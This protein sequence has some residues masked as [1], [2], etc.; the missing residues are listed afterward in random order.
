MKKY[1]RLISLLLA[2]VLVCLSAVT[3]F[4]ED[5]DDELEQKLWEL[6]N[7]NLEMF[8]A[9]GIG[10]DYYFY[11]NPGDP[12]P[13]PNFLDTIN[14]ESAEETCL[15]ALFMF[16]TYEEGHTLYDGEI[17]L[18]TATQL[19]D[20][21]RYEL[22]N[23]VID[24]VEVE[25]LVAIC[26]KESNGNSYYDEQF[27]ADFQEEI[28]QAKE[29]LADESI[30]DLRV[31]TAFYELMYQYNLLCTY[32]KVAKDIDNDGVMTIMD[33]TYIQRFLVKLET[34]NTSQLFLLG[35]EG[36]FSPEDVTIIYATRIQRFCAKISQ[37]GYGLNYNKLIE[38]I[39]E[40]NPESEN[41]GYDSI[42]W[43]MMY[44]GDQRSE[45]IY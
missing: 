29:L 43:N 18:E 14:S 24:R 34:L 1:K 16:L 27:W 44:Y 38:H 13:D 39:E 37:P 6:Y 4:A 12:D 25:E 3:A 45:G 40:T 32:N 42:K 7:L 9:F 26:E 30:V 5:T 15:D 21:L 31:N 20:K 11:P 23:L 2:L 22:E 35:G 8:Y 19:Y 36:H 10:N 33:A 41:F 17:N 28:T